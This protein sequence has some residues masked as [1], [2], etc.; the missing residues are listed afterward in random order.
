[1]SE[2]SQRLMVSGGNV[3][4]ITDQ[5]EREGLVVRTVAWGGLSVGVIAALL[6]LAL[7]DVALW[8]VIAFFVI[9]DFTECNRKTGPHLGGGAPDEEQAIVP[10]IKH[11]HRPPALRLRFG[12][13]KHGSTLLGQSKGKRFA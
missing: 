11:G 4:G 13:V 8:S 10:V 2:V 12:G 6:P 3:T 1:M 7:G 9:E 5:L